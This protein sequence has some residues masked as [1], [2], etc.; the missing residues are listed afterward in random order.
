[1]INDTTFTDGKKKKTGEN[2]QQLFGNPK[3]AFPGHEVYNKIQLDSMCK[4][5]NAASE[6][7]WAMQD[8]RVRRA[9]RL[10][11]KGS[12][13]SFLRLAVTNEKHLK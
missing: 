10:L 7:V 8:A 3:I 9:R 13:I 5:R 11:L 1:M 4:N 6:Q 12:R 2:Q